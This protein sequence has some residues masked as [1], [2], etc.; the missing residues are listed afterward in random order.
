MGWESRWVMVIMLIECLHASDSSMIPSTVRQSSNSIF[1]S[2]PANADDSSHDC[3]DPP[4]ATRVRRIGPPNHPGPA[5]SSPGIRTLGLSRTLTGNLQRL[6]V[7][8]RTR[9]IRWRHAARSGPATPRFR[10]NSHD[11][12]SW[13]L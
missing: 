5:R 7:Q 2:V 11:D 1:W 12:T 8:F 9:R 4:S 10:T 13:A 3:P 6:T